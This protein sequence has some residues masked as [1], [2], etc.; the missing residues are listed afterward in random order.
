MTRRFAGARFAV[1]MPSYFSEHQI[2]HQVPAERWQDGL[3]MGN[4]DLEAISYEDGGFSW[5][6]TKVDV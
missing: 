5:G 1:E 3:P 6:V 2:I 4:G